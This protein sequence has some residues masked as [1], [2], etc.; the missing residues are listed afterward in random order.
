MR[1]I[2]ENW[3]L[4]QYYLISQQNSENEHQCSLHIYVKFGKSNLFLGTLE[5]IM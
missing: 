2:I 1:K 5:S 3:Q 4:L